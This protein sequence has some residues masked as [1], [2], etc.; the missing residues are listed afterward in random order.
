MKNKWVFRVKHDENTSNPRYKARLVVKGFSQRK[1]IDFEE[2][3]S[4]VVKMSSIRIV[5]SLAAILDLEIEQMDVR[6]AFLHGD[7]EEEIY[8]IQPEGFVV[9][10]KENC[11]CKL[12]KSLYGL[13]QAPRQWYKKFESFMGKHGYIKTTSDHCV[14]MKKFSSDDFVILLI[15]VDGMLIIG[16]NASRITSLKREL[17]KSFAMKDLGTA[18]QILG[19]KIIRDRKTK[20]LWLSHEKYIEK[21][22]QRFNMHKAKPVSTPLGA[23]FKLSNKQSPTTEEDKKAMEK[24]PYALATGSLMYAMICTRPD[25]AHSVGVI[26]RFVSNPGKE[27]WHAVKWLMRYL[28]GTS[29]MCLCFGAKHTNLVAY[30]DLDM[31]GDV[32]GRRSISGYLMTYAGGSVSWQSRLQ[33]CV[34]LSTTEAEFI[35]ATEASKELLWVKKFMQELN[36]VQDKYVLYYDNESAIHLGKNPAFHARSKHIDVRYH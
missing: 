17:T 7:L 13:T 14:F 29:N 15:Y 19:L 27:H 26:S 6:T 24:I 5:L 2:I 16:N 8:M 34:A 25:I 22:L 20:R 21:V 30:T 33:K 12:K 32:D 28:R 36:F 23:H 4:P 11:V 18:S 31:A 3:F 1:G 35:A 10:G 9:K